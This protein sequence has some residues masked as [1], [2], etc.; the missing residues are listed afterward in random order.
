MLVLSTFLVLK[1]CYFAIVYIDAQQQQNQATT[2]TLDVQYDKYPPQLIPVSSSSSAPTTINYIMWTP[3]NWT[4][5]DVSFTT[6]TRGRTAHR[7][8]PLQ[9]NAY[10]LTTTSIQSLHIIVPSMSTS[11]ARAT[12]KA[13]TNTGA[14]RIDTK[15]ST[16]IRKQAPLS[17]NVNAVRDRTYSSGIMHHNYDPL[18][19]VSTQS[20]KHHCTYAMNGGPFHSDGS[21]VG[22][23][24]VQNGTFLS[25]DFGPNIGFGIATQRRMSTSDV[26]NT[27][28]P[29]FTSFWVMGRIDTE[30][31]AR[32]IGI[33]QF[34]TGFDWLVYNFTNIV[35]YRDDTNVASSRA[36]RS[37]IGIT[38]DGTV[39]LL[40]T[41]GCEHW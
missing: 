27:T 32:R 41:D 1:F 34:M 18:Q 6:T 28:T 7:K 35:L 21:S 17:Y 26:K 2:T 19:R 22:I 31:Q 30:D 33:Q 10:L 20:K 11:Y 24:M 13:D 29:L 36:S 4:N 5:P 16:V 40:V 8:P 3:K 25:K 12:K 9:Y 37:T 14:I 23:V 39:L 15:S 38:A